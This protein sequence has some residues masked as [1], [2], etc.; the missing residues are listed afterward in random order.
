MTRTLRFVTACLL[1]TSVLACGDFDSGLDDTKKVDQLTTEESE[2]LC[3]SANDYT[4]SQI[5]TE[6]TQK[7]GC[8]FGGLLTAE[9][10]VA[11]NPMAD[12]AQT[13]TSKYE[14]CLME[15]AQMQTSEDACMNAMPPS[16]CDVTIAEYEDCIQERTLL[17]KQVLADISCDPMS[18]Q[19]AL[20]VEQGP[21]CQALKEKCPSALQFQDSTPSL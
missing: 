19:N 12:Y 8:Y 13:C 3:T 6:E 5:S 18:L 7:F 10:T 2:Q 14:E 15:P 17:T 1:T 4:S 20:T 11:L 21:R 16:N 9:F